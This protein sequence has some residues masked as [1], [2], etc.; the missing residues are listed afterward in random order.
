MPAFGPPEPVHVENEWYDGPRAGV[1]DIHGVPHRFVSQWDEKDEELLGT[2]FVWPIGEAE[3]ALER[4]QW[5]IF[6]QW[7][8]EYEA[9]NAST[10]T[11]PGHPGTN[12]RWDEISTILQGA[13]QAV[14]PAAKRAK[15][16]LRH[17]DREERYTA[18]GPSYELS[19]ALL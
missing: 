12:P 9:G 19:W 14:P 10:D 18:S 11:H 15:A 4:E 13:R 7:N 6:V 2:F 8:A 5:L 16:E 3:L 1:A 17:L